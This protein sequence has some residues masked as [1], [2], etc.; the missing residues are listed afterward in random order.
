MEFYANYSP[1]ASFCRKI[2]CTWVRSPIQMEMSGR[3]HSKHWGLWSA[4]SAGT[5][6]NTTLVCRFFKLLQVR[7]HVSLSAIASTL[8]QFRIT[9][10]DATH[11][12]PFWN[13]ETLTRLDF[14]VFQKL[15]WKIS[16]GTIPKRMPGC[17]LPSGPQRVT[18]AG[19]HCQLSAQTVTGCSTGCS[20][21]PLGYP[22]HWALCSHTDPSRE[23]EMGLEGKR[24]HEGVQGPSSF[25]S[26]LQVH[27]LFQYRQIIGNSPD[28]SG[29]GSG[30]KE[31]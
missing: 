5:M 1:V 22:R 3:G 16:P 23:L 15:V 21:R 8:G 14:S 13:S 11:C 26:F 18:S 12:H 27:F 31:A 6:A 9:L 19:G 29:G 28:M 7:N 4:L 10:S 25:R 20:R 30:E 24:G 2:L 17:L